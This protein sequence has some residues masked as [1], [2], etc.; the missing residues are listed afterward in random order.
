MAFTLSLTFAFHLP[1]LAETS[2]PPTSMLFKYQT[3]FCF[4]WG[5]NALKKTDHYICS[6]P[7]G[8]RFKVYFGWLNVVYSD[9]ICM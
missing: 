2:P 7:L 3:M 8:F 9:V 5:F 4:F 1:D 6:C